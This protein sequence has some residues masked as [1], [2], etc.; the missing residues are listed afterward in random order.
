VPDA[1][2]GAEA[3]VRG[4]VVVGVAV[5][6]GEALTFGVLSHGGHGAL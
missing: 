3:A 4:A 6:G 5:T 2:R 1:L